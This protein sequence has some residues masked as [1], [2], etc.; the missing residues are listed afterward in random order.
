MY[1]CNS[2]NFTAIY[3]SNYDVHLKTSKH[4]KL[5]C[6][7][8]L[9][10][11]FEETYQEA[12]KNKNN[13]SR[14]MTVDNIK[15]AQELIINQLKL[16]NNT[17]IPK[18]ENNP[19]NIGDSDIRCIL[20]RHEVYDTDFIDKLNLKNITTN[21]INKKKFVAFSDPNDHINNC[22]MNEI[23]K[24]LMHNNIQTITNLLDIIEVM[25]TN[26]LSLHSSYKELTESLDKFKSKDYEK[27][28]RKLKLRYTQNEKIMTK[29]ELEFNQSKI[30]IA[31]LTQENKSQLI[32]Q[33]MNHSNNNNT[34]NKNT[35]NISNCYVA[36]GEKFINAPNI[37][38]IE[39]KQLVDKYLSVK[40]LITDPVI[41]PTTIPKTIPDKTTKLSI[42]QFKVCGFKNHD[43]ANCCLGTLCASNYVKENYLINM[44]N[45]RTFKNNNHN[46]DHYINVFTD[47][48]T[49][50][51][52]KNNPDRS[53]LWS[54]DSNRNVFSVKMQVDN[55]SKFIR[56]TNGVQVDKYPIG[57]LINYI[58]DMLEKYKVV[59]HK[60]QKIYV[61]KF[62]KL[63]VC[64]AIKF[65]K[66]C[67]INNIK[68][69]AGNPRS[70]DL[71]DDKTCIIYNNRVINSRESQKLNQI[72]SD[73]KES[74]EKKITIIE[75][76]KSI[77][78]TDKF[79]IN[80]K[81]KLAKHYHITVAQL[82]RLFDCDNNINKRIEYVEDNCEEE[83]EDI[84]EDRVVE[85]EEE[86]EK[87]EEAMIEEVYDLYD[88]C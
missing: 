13:Y 76:I 80:I 65:E 23:H 49:L 26:F 61:D 78:K 10:N 7:T 4:R 8:I 42:K 11:A 59:I 25:N 28:Y 39:P 55:V 37:N 44:Y 9:N 68:L 64:H 53:S 34:V 47:M 41:V 72:I 77:V 36:M 54:T 57:L 69:K 87:E 19:V 1:T 31:R 5:H 40:G 58:V 17:S 14:V 88:S 38:L 18:Y 82:K 12:K 71:K 43:A 24:L 30:E 3:K 33:T 15:N 6:E 45:E 52:D 81:K 2:C 46:I 35:Y 67:K 84:V 21:P 27:K 63:T 66:E 56:D 48:I 22:H 70:N 85:N 20:C 16:K 74:Y 73:I 75:H 62:I 83:E 60:S 86:E 79:S 51:Y 32:N 29:L 50:F